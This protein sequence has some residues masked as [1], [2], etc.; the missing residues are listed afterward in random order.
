MKS[1]CINAIKYSLLCFCLSTTTHATVFVLPASGDVIGEL[2][3]TA[4][5]INE[6]IDEAGRRF[7]VGY[8]E[9]VH[10]NPQVD[11]IHTLPAHTKLLVPTQYILPDVPRTGIVI[12]LAEYRLYY[13][14]PDENIVITFPVGIGK[15]GWNTPLGFTKVTAKTTN[16]IWRP[17]PK[18][19]AA[20]EELGAPLPDEFPS[21]VDNPLGKYALR[22]GWPA[23]LIHGT[24]RTD[25]VGA[26]V[27]AGCI[28]MLPEDIEE[29]YSL[30]SVGTSVRVINEP[31]KIGRQDDR[32]LIQMYPLLK[33]MQSRNLN[34]ILHAKLHKAGINAVLDNKLISH[35]LSY[36]SGLIKSVKG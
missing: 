33:G 13:F 35:E 22:L 34:K 1:K 20:A 5:R 29:L 6:T 7:N 23:Y 10:A 17:T 9:M 3:H 12:N 32:L 8:Y 25:G 19:L 28:R 26:R 2:Q 21:G 4:S 11:A 36:P 31:V 27:S 16:P 14:P 18:L 24:N 15:E 30:V